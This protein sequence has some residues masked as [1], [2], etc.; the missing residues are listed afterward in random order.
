MVVDAFD[1]E[2]LPVLEPD[3][4]GHYVAPAPS[5]TPTTSAPTLHSL[6]GAFLG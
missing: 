1:G 6:V 5:A 2:L 4:V 3:W